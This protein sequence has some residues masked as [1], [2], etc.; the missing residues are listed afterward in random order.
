MVPSDSFNKRIMKDLKPLQKQLWIVAIAAALL[1]L[2]GAL[3]ASSSSTQL[4]KPNI[5]LIFIDD[6]G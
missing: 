6:M 1:L 2:S 4:I 3:L 5:V